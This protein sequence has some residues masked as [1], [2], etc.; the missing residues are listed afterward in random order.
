MRGVE[1]GKFFLCVPFSNFDFEQCEYIYLS[2]TNKSMVME[3][4]LTWGGEHT[5]Q[6]TDMR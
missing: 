3:G 2:K 6:Y 1:E 5:M 4:D